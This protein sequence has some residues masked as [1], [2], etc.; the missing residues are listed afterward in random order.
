MAFSSYVSRIIKL[1]KIHQ[2]ELGQ[3]RRLNNSCKELALGSR[4]TRETQLFMVAADFQRFW[5]TTTVA[6]NR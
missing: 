2:A 3:R 5:D 1:I 6:N 4:Y